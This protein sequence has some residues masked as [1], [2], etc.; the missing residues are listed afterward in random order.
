MRRKILVRV[1]RRK[2][3]KSLGLWGGMI[4]WAQKTGLPSL[5]LETENHSYVCSFI[6]SSKKYP[7]KRY[8]S[9]EEFCQDNYDHF[10]DKLNNAFIKL[11]WL[12]K[13]EVSMLSDGKRV[14]VKK[15]YRS[16]GYS[17]LYL[18]TYN[19][20]YGKDALDK[21]FHFYQYNFGHG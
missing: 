13:I 7:N 14:A 10:A 21:R 19:T 6:Y 4:L 12:R 9:L 2:L 5:T 16:K 18:R 20:A 8:V 15:Y 1:D 11:G 17:K 3:I